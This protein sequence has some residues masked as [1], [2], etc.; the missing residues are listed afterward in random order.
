MDRTE[1]WN[2]AKLAAL[3]DLLRRRRET[4]TTV[5]SC[6]GGLLA[7]RITDIPG[8][9]D[10]FHQGFITYC[11]EAKA[12]LAGVSLDTLAKYTAVSS[13]TAREMARGGAKS[14]GADA[15]LSVTGYAG[16]P[17]GPEDDTVGLVYAGCFYRGKT[18][19]KELHLAGN[20]RRIREAAVEEALLLLE[21]SLTSSAV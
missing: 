13:Q 3:L 20:R 7:G 17:Q 2:D 15:C 14:A 19:V 21:E 12:R 4:V 9:S 1:R 8:S 18:L 16:P 10:V 11:D 5:E 6:T